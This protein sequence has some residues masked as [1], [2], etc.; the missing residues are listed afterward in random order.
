MPPPQKGF[1]SIIHDDTHY[2]WMFQN[3]TGSNELIIELSAS[4]GG[5]TLIADVPKIVN[6]EMIRSAIDY[7][8]ANGWAPNE[9]GPPYRCVYR[10][11]GFTPKD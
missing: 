4:V 6:H 11:S 2:R 8:R 3:R 7:G 5:Q 9:S 10:R 1:K